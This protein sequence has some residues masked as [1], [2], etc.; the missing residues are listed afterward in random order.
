MIQDLIS[1]SKPH[2][3]KTIEIFKKDLANL[4]TGRA[5]IAL[6]EDLPVEYYGSRLTLKE[7]ATISVGEPKTILIKPWDKNS[8]SAIEKAIRVSQLGLNPI[9]D[10]DV[11]RLSLPPLTEERRKEFIKIVH[12]KAEEARIA[13][14]NIREKTLKDLKTL[15]EKGNLREDEFFKAKENLQKTVDDYNKQVEELTKNKEKELMS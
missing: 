13:I 8:I 14:R 9:V 4:R 2:F 15:E 12:Q 10:G 11:V 5:S 3:D 1:K 7:L 6:V